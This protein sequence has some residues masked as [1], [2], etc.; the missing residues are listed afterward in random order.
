MTRISSGRA[1]TEFEERLLRETPKEKWMEVLPERS[2]EAC[3]NKY[4]QLLQRERGYKKTRGKA[5]VE[6]TKEEFERE[7]AG[8]WSA[9]EVTYMS[10]SIEELWDVA[11]PWRTRAEC[12]ARLKWEL[13]R[14]PVKK[15]DV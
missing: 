9:D 12:W 1:W 11:F 7:M 10:N 15:S 4:Y 5:V 6:L 13:G 14:R 2:I 3:R 8:E